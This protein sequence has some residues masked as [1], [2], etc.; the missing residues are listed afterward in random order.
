MH[1][2]FTNMSPQK[3]YLKKPYL[4]ADELCNLLKL[5]IGSIETRL[6]VTCKLNIYIAD[7]DLNVIGFPKII[8]PND[9]LKDL[10][11]LKDDTVSLDYFTMQKNMTHLFSPIDDLVNKK[12]VDA[13]SQAN[14]V[15]VLYE[16][17]YAYECAQHALEIARKELEA[18]AM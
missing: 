2:H 11:L 7:N 9:A 4:L 13:V 5:P 6:A 3:L 18:A 14:A 15:K 8:K 10:L 17:T 1:G 12:H 16:A